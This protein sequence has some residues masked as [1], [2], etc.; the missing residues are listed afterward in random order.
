MGL[1]VRRVPMDFS[2][3][4]SQIWSGY[5]DPYV[6]QRIPCQDCEGDGL[7]RWAKLYKQQWDGAAPFDPMAYGSPEVLTDHLGNVAW[8]FNL[9]Q[10]DIEALRKRELLDRRLLDLSVSEINR[11]TLRL[12]NEN[13]G[14]L[15]SQ[16]RY[17]CISNR[18][19]HNRVPCSC[20]TCRGDGS[21]YPSQELEFLANDWV[22]EDPPTGPGWQ[23]WETVTEGSPVS[24]VMASAQDLA[25]WCANNKLLQSLY[26]GDESRWLA[27]ILQGS[28]MSMII[29]ANGEVLSGVQ[30]TPLPNPGA[31]TLGKDN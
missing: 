31:T 1:Q 11:F 30:A 25:N 27:M 4:I 8:K 10:D 14:W 3:P 2:W 16:Q 24:P 22:P 26:G 5:I 17:T 7:S 9:N 13:R 29:T 20:Q 21:V 15:Y 19:R 6:T 28:C 23:M 18:C 12:A